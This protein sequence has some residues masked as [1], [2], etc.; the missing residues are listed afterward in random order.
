MSYAIKVCLKCKGRPKPKGEQMSNKKVAI[1]N[2]LD[3]YSKWD[4]RVFPTNYKTDSG[5]SCKK[6]ELCEKAGKHPAVTGYQHLASTQFKRL[7]TDKSLFGGKFRNYDIGALAGYE[8]FVVD[9]DRGELE[10]MPKTWKSKSANR[11]Y[12]YFFKTPSGTQIKNIRELI[13]NVDI[14]GMGGLVVLPS[15]VN[16][17]EWI[18]PPHE[19]DLADAPAWILEAIREHEQNIQKRE[20]V[21]SEAFGGL[22]FSDG[23]LE[24]GARNDTLFRYGCY[25]RSLSMEDEILPQITIMNEKRCNPPLGVHELKDIARSARRYSLNDDLADILTLF[26][27]ALLSIHWKGKAGKSNRSILVALLHENEERY[28]VTPEGLEVSISYR[29][30]AEKTGLSKKSVYTRIKQTSYLKKGKAPKGN[31]SGTII[32]VQ[33]SL[34]KCVPTTTLTSNNIRGEMVS[35]VSTTHKLLLNSIRWTNL[36]KSA[37]L[38]LE[39]LMDKPFKRKDLEEKLVYSQGGVSSILKKLKDKE[40]IQAQNGV[41]SLVDD[42]D[43]KIQSF[44]DENR[45]DI[46]KMK[47]VHKGDREDYGLRLEAWK[48]AW[49]DES[50]IQKTAEEVNGIYYLKVACDSEAKYQRVRMRMLYHYDRLIS[51]LDDQ[52]GKASREEVACAS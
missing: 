22:A 49:A 13:P 44:L 24:E 31:K 14:K 2:L 29:K 15:E 10:G 12:H 51:G 4:F 38:I 6:G 46:E 9:S 43:E 3:Y 50:E 27:E 8:W 37:A 20:E 5:C 19:T 28:E 7:T 25:L 40:L 36:G 26:R 42:F 18:N 48:R 45:K 1:P 11:G 16:N 39:T 17:R 33:Q 35:V 41:Y 47:K 23:I 32:I 30:L 34:L 21:Y 52:E